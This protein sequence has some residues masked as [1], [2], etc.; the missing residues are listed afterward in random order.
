M[1]MTEPRDDDDAMLESY[2]TAARKAAPEPPAD[3]LTRVAAAA[4]AGMVPEPAP[5]PQPRGL[6]ALVAGIGGWPALA[7]LATA[8]AAGVYLGVLA[9]Q[10][11]DLLMLGGSGVDLGAFQPG[12]GVF[13]GE[14]G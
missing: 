3:L 4:E 1:S 11:L 6:K 13:L 2:F 9:P 14:S 10:T 8:T 7:G 5:A 12:Y